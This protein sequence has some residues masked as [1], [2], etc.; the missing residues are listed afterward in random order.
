[1][2]IFDQNIVFKSEESVCA[3]HTLTRETK[4]GCSMSSSAKC[5]II[6]KTYHLLALIILPILC[7]LWCL[8]MWILRTGYGNIKG[9]ARFANPSSGRGELIVSF[10]PCNVCLNIDFTDFIDFNFLPLSI[11]GRKKRSLFGDGTPQANYKVVKTDYTSYS[12]VYNCNPIGNILKKGKN[13]NNSSKE[14]LFL[15]WSEYD[16]LF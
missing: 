9:S 14:S 12:V 3:P 5:K 16:F 8:Y 13:K 1:M 11:V 7:T 6:F 15:K 2:L 10:N 4:L